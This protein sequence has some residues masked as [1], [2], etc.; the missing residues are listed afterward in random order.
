MRRA[1]LPCLV[2]SARRLQVAADLLEAL[3]GGP[4][5]PAGRPDGVLEAMLDVVVDQGGLGLLERPDDRVELLGDVRAVPPDSIMPL[6]VCR[7]PVARRSRFTTSLW[8]R[9]VTASWAGTWAG[10]W[11]WAA[12]FAADMGAL[13]RRQRRHSYPLPGDR[14]MAACQGPP[15]ARP[16]AANMRRHAP[17]HPLPVDRP[18]RRLA[19]VGLRRLRR[20]ALQL[21]GAQRGA[22][23]ARPPAGLA[24]GPV[25]HPLL[26]WAAHVPVP[27]WLGGGGRDLRADQRPLRPPPDPDD[28]DGPVRRSGTAACAFVTDIWQLTACRLIASLGI[29]GEWAAGAA[30]VAEVVDE[31]HRVEAGALLYTAAP[32]GLFLATGVN[33]LVAGNLMTGE[34]RDQLAIRPAVRPA[35]GGRRPAR[36]PV[37]QGAGPLGDD[38]ARPRRRRASGSCSIRSSGH[39]PAAPC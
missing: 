37:R 31:E 12:V 19:R 14:S 2:P 39:G 8:V 22:H 3:D 1:T 28:H 34:P 25:G 33:A 38:G 15:I 23:A 6:I 32:F 20:A 10:P 24:G 17:L 35:A 9:W 30:M 21:R 29:G 4:L 18:R 27:D 11:A 16:G 7:W 5:V 26:D 13:G 36:A